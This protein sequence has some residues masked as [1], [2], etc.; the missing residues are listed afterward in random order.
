M[1]L[2]YLVSLLQE[3]AAESRRAVV[4]PEDSA[5]RCVVSAYTDLDCE[6]LD[7]YWDDIQY[8]ATGPSPDPDLWPMRGTS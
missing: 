8:G 2:T 1:C 5:P 4:D 6:L 3:S 7:G